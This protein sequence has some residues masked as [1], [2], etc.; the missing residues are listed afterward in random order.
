VEVTVST[1]K[2]CVLVS[3]ASSIVVLP[4]RAQEKSAP[5]KTTA[6]P[7]VTSGTTS[8][9]TSDAA[10]DLSKDPTLFVV[11]YAHLDTQWR[12]IYPQTIREFLAN[13]L[14]DNFALIERYPHYVF[15][16]TG[17]RRYQFF[18]EYFP[19]EYEK[20]KSYVAAGRWFPC[21]SSVDEND[22]NTPSGESFVRQVLYGNHFFRRE[23]GTASEEYMLPDCFGF[24]AA[25]PSVLAH[26]GIK[27]FST[28]K[29]TWNS[30]VGIP[31]N[32]GYWEGPDGRGVTTALN[33]GQYDGDVKENLATS[34][35]WSK[36]I[37]ADGQRS[38]VF[39]DYHYYGTGDVGGAPK[40]ASVAMVEESLATKGPVHVVAGPADDLFKAITPA[41][42]EHLP[43]YKGELELTEH[44]AGS[45]TSQ[46]FM[47][48][49]N[50][51]NELLA[52]AAEKSSVAAAWLGG[53][54]YP[55]QKLENAWTL[56][57]GSQMHDIV[58]GTALAKGYEYAWN[59][60]LLAANQFAS[61]L[62]DAVG[63]VAGVMNTKSA[64]APDAQSDG[65]PLVVF[66][67]LSLEREDVVEAELA[68]SPDA[69]K[70]VSVTG[71]DGKPVAAQ[72]LDA[73]N[74]SVRIA[75]LAKVPSV[76]FAVF[77]VRMDS[78]PS[79]FESA[80]KVDEHQLE[81]ER[82][83]VK[84]DLNGDVASVFDRNAKR[85]LLSA[86]ARLG[87]HY[88]NPR[89]W[90]A[91]NQ[92]WT[93]RQL[94]AKEYAAGPARVRVVERGPARVAVEIA[95][96]VA[97]STITQRVRLCAGG[98]ADRVEFDT[99]IAWTT[100]ERSLRAAFPLSASNPNATYDIQLGTLERPNAHAK[101]YEYGFQ[102]WMDL[103]D[104]SGEF[105]ASIL[106]DSKFG[107]DKPDNHTL[108]LTLLHTP[109]TRGGYEDQGTQDLGR[110]RV[111][112]AL[113]G[114]AGDWR[115]GKIAQQAARLN[116]PLLAFRATPHDGKLGTSLSLLATSD[117][118]VRVQAI[119]KIEDGDEIV[120]R[121]RELSGTDKK[122][123]R[124]HAASDVTS[125]REVDG[126]ERELRGQERE[127]AQASIQ[128]G[129]LVTDVHGYG[130]RA[131]ALRFADPPARAASSVSVSIPLSLDTDVASTN[132]NRTDGAIDASGRTLPAEQL[133][134]RIVAEDATFVLGSTLDG[135]KNALACKA[136][137]IQIPR[138]AANADRVYLLAAADASPIAS[139]SSGPSSGTAREAR[140]RAKVGDTDVP[141]IVPSWTGFIGQWDHRLWHSERPEANDDWSGG[142]A[143]IEPAYVER[144]PVAWFATHGHTKSGDAFYEFSY[145]FK[146]AIDVPSGAKSITLPD[147]PRI[148]VLAACAVSSPNGRVSAAA[149]LFDALDDHAQDAPRVVPPAGAFHDATLVRIEPGMYWRADSIR[150]TLDG[151]AP[152]AGSPAYAGPFYLDHKALIRTAV[153]QSDGRTGPV[154]QA[155]LDV[156]DSTP[157]KVTRVMPAYGS[158]LVRISFSEPVDDSALDAKVYA[159]EPRVEVR[160]AS[161]KAGASGAR[162]IVLEL[163]APLAIDT[164]YRLTIRGVKDTSP[165]HN[166]MN[167]TTLDVKVAG[168]VFSVENVSSEAM[169]H[170]MRDVPNL[171]VK[172][173]DAWT[174]CM[175]V[176]P[177]K[178]PDDRTIIA[179]FGRCEQAFE[180]SAR[181]L[182]KFQRGIRFWSHNRDVDGRTPLDVGKWQ[183]LAA[184]YDG[185]VLRVYKDAK[186]IGE[187]GVTLADDESIVNF[188]P[189]DPWEHTRRFD[190]EIRGFK[191]WR[192]ALSDEALKSLSESQPAK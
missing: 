133:P 7:V 129:E 153:V 70:G 46:A 151:S 114:H 2:L 96:D 105:G 166:E 56:V 21:G 187:R 119:K 104:T 87:L 62:E 185:K 28:Q 113:C 86:P 83:V 97:G 136:Q 177:A 175:S 44:S 42:Q 33:P 91:W 10:P 16:F 150:Y 134:A 80:L 93:D 182:A 11:G 162:E 179:G 26:C 143:G 118:D 9:A 35:T 29:L 6:A 84:I 71:P 155:Q 183:M 40:E 66:N 167:A 65:T 122:G 12:W 192:E 5:S 174:L 68:M 13:T 38:G 154:T 75:F 15:N 139:A 19:A 95:R 172:A 138:A 1:S 127:L 130:L 178:Q 60:E 107:S 109:G 85:E 108:R 50:R 191:I 22:C 41:M 186:K 72:I 47:K 140:A 79:S 48:R 102:Q 125:A 53:R 188:A 43:H 25:L 61:V 158:P 74:G 34:E 135:E 100:R 171:P 165:M 36:R 147:D 173:D 146:I 63:V 64:R 54:E 180:G 115:Q 141:L 58:S 30:V 4:M 59:D 18:K 170:E 110:H 20:L 37:A 123:V 81:N 163:A 88:E 27:G 190:G 120:V 164:R 32:V 17:S 98:A 78:K 8:E 126:Q 106:C 94:P 124:I 99:D 52:D 101:Q 145:L 67:P 184:T 3:L 55:A 132:A 176:R 137:T 148:K 89:Q 69:A 149:P 144:T 121:V 117:D 24:P 161:R 116:Q 181:Y 112:Y 111:L 23:L 14:H 159:L 152:S 82:Y 57:L 168:P 156:D 45:L 49:M 160:S 142:L 90:P 169:G 189:L 77:Q 76:G 103:T 73:K 31:F 51:K 39:A 131:F 157:P 128:N 92:D